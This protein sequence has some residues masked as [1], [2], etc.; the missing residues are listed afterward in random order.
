MLF[1]LGEM[2]S[3]FLAGMVSTSLMLMLGAYIERLENK[4]VH[5]K[6]TARRQTVQS[7]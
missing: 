1:T 4:K 5:D 7:N 6:R 2:F 3:S